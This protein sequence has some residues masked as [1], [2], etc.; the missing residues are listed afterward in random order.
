[1][2]YAKVGQKCNMLFWS[3]GSVSDLYVYDQSGWAYSI[4]HNGNRPDAFDSD[5][6]IILMFYPMQISGAGIHREGQQTFKNRE[7]P[8]QSIFCDEKMLGLSAL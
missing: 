3:T 8:R 7:V 4:I 1:M 6:K 5:N 2:Q